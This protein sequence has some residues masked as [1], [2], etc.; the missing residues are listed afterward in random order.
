[1]SEQK[2][3]AYDPDIDDEEIPTPALVGH[4]AYEELAQQLTLMEAKAN[5]YWDK[6]LRCQA[7]LDNNRRRSERDLAQA[8]KFGLERFV[9]ELLP[10]ADNLERSLEQEN[11]ADAA[12]LKTGVELTLKLLQNVLEKL[13]VKPVNP[14][15]EM[16]DPTLHEAMSMQ[17]HAEK[18]PGTVLVVLQKG[19]LLND[20]LLRP[21]LVVVAKAAD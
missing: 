18:A 17:A 13:A 12:A 21:A 1:M 15:D 7:E 3:K 8:H 14:L 9:L 6:L 2:A 19:Y 16:F 11:T 20:R 5:D 10:V 4:P